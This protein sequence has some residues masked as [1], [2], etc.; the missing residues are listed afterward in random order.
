MLIGEVICEMTLLGKDRSNFKCQGHG[1][2]GTLHWCA[3]KN[4]FCRLGCMFPPC[5]VLLMEADFIS[6]NY[7]AYQQLIVQI[8]IR[9][10]TWQKKSLYL[11]LSKFLI[12][13]IK[14]LPKLELPVTFTII[15]YFNWG[16]RWGRVGTDRVHFDFD[17]S[18]S[19]FC[20]QP[21]LDS[22]SS[23]GEDLQVKVRFNT[24]SRGINNL[25]MH[26]WD[27]E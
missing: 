6:S 4:Y 14:I 26:C 21:R 17:P 9:L 1:T 25:N 13:A 12:F 20:F 24:M 22:R 7:S 16:V 3:S 11:V 10:I 15:A 23:V 27:V 5:P 8:E 18:C 2:A 19:S